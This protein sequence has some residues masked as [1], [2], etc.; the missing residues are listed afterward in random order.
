MFKTGWPKLKLQ[1]SL[2]VSMMRAR[3][4]SRWRLLF[5][6]SPKFLDPEAAQSHCLSSS[7][8][9]RKVRVQAE[10]I[11]QT[12]KAGCVAEEKKERLQCSQRN[13]ELG[14]HVV[15]ACSSP[16]FLTHG[17]LGTGPKWCALSF[18]AVGM[19]SSKFSLY[20]FLLPCK[21]LLRP[22]PS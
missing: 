6:C 8:S 5:H 13:L 1:A 4:R 11:P 7:P 19:L 17:H 3:A 22:H 20:S 18:S 14:E 10:P 21:L 2:S 9:I 12:T 15:K 16:Y